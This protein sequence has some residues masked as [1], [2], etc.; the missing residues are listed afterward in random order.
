LGDHQIWFRVFHILHC[1]CQTL[2]KQ[3]K[4]SAR[5]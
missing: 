3:R 5:V 4:Q 1:N 2:L